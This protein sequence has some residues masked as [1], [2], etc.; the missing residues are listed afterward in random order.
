MQANILV[1]DLG[2]TYT[3]AAAFRLEGEG[4]YGLTSTFIRA[5]QLVTGEALNYANYKP[6][7]KM[8]SDGIVQPYF[9]TPLDKINVCE[10]AYLSVINNA[11]D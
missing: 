1:Y 9:D 4:V 10:N 8:K 2:S 11:K 5:W 3:K 7:V 6:T